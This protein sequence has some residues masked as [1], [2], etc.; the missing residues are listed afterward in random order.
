MLSN[1]L[2]QTPSSPFINS[3]HR[4]SGGDDYLFRLVLWVFSLIS[5]GSLIHFHPSSS[6]ST[7]IK[8]FGGEQGVFFHAEATIVQRKVHAY[9]KGS[10]STI[11]TVYLEL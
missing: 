2:S 9:L 11:P 5:H 4:R 10:E 7:C 3:V 1:S 8:F 6:S